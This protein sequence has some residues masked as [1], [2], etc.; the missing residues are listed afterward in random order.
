MK[1]LT[2]SIRPFVAM[3]VALGVSACGGYTTVSLGG[4]V[5]GLTS[6]GLVLANGNSTV[7]IPA[8]ATAYTFPNQIGDQSEYAVTIQSQPARLT[9]TLTN[10]AARATGISIDWVNVS[11]SPNTYTVGGSITGLS[12]N[13]LVLVNGGDTVNVSAGSTSF[14]FPTPVADGAVYGIAVLSQ[15]PGLTCSIVNGTAAMGA[16]NVTNVQVNCI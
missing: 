14:V 15:P 3:A 6:D 16:G 2:S 5:A 7:A 12:V 11:C 13:G 10:A 4:K 8:N 9:C 1:S